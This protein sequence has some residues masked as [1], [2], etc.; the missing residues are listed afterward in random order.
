[1]DSVVYYR[2]SD[3]K[4]IGHTTS[5]GRVNIEKELPHWG[6]GV[7]SLRVPSVNHEATKIFRVINGQLVSENDPDAISDNTNKKALARSAFM[8]L[9]TIT[10]L[11]NTE[12]LVI[13][14]GIR[15]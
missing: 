10:G 9:K 12:I 4:V 8:K 15:T 7:S 11:T 14:R 13:F 1:M 3:G 2:D 6:P 5:H